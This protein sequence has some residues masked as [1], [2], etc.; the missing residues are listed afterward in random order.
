MRFITAFFSLSQLP[1]Q[2][3]LAYLKPCDVMS[4]N[5]T[6]KRVWTDWPFRLYKSAQLLALTHT[7][8]ASSFRTRYLGN[9]LKLAIC[10][11]DQVHHSADGSRGVKIVCQSFDNAGFRF[12]Q[13]GWRGGRGGGSS[14]LNYIAESRRG[15]R[16][17][18]TSPTER[19]PGLSR[20][21]ADPSCKP[22]R[23][24][25]SWR[26]TPENSGPPT[27]CHGC[28]RWLEKKNPKQNKKYCNT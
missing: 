13:P 14:W 23:R 9:R 3:W 26:W 11:M 17:G 20:S 2:K 19:L 16:C 18:R 8:Y 7:T 24:A 4:Q 15:H 5:Q 21:G 25:W 1:A 22:E 6:K 27:C 28:S 12:S 10:V